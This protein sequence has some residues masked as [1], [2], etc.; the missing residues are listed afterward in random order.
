MIY[1]RQPIIDVFR[2]VDDV[3][4]LGVMDLRG[5]SQPYFFVLTR[6]R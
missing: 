2:R 4:L 6:G 5:M 1:D 3:T